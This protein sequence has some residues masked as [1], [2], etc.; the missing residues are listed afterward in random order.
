MELDPISKTPTFSELVLEHICFL[1]FFFTGW[2]SFGS[3]LPMEISIHDSTSHSR[4]T[5][6][7]HKVFMRGEN[8]LRPNQ[9]QISSIFTKPPR[10]RIIFQI[11]YHYFLKT[12]L[13]TVEFSIGMKCSNL[14]SKLRGIKSADDMYIKEFLEG[15]LSPLAKQI[16]LECSKNRPTMLFTSIF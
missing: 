16:I 1:I 9:T 15:K 8:F 11:T 3:L 12:C 6:V 2:K 14:L 7:C 5:R 13:R 4:Q 10:V